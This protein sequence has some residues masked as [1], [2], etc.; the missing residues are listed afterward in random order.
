M[1]IRKTLFE[2]SLLLFVFN[3]LISQSIEIELYGNE[4]LPAREIKRKVQ[5]II[6]GGEISYEKIETLK[7]EILNLY[8]ENGFYF[9]R[10]DSIKIDGVLKIYL[11]EGEQ[12][13]VGE[14]EISGNKLFSSEDIFR[15]S[16]FKRGEIFLPRILKNRIGK[17][18]DA[19]ANVGYPLAEIEI[20]DLDF[21]DDGFVNFK[22]K[23]TE[24]KLIRIDQ[25][26]IEGN[27]LTKEDLILREMRIKKGEIYREGKLNQVKKRLTKIGLFESVEEPIIFLSDTVAG[28]LIR[29]KEAKTNFFDGV[30][31]YVPKTETTRGYFTGYINI[32]LKNL[33]G[34]GRRFGVKWN[35]ET[36]ETQEFELNY[37][38]PYVLNFPLSAEVYF[39][40]RKQDSSYVVR[41]PKLNFSAELTSSEKLSEILKTSFYISRKVVIPTATEFIGYQI[42]ESV[43]LNV[44]FGILYDSRDNVDFPSS[45]VYFSSFYELGS[46]RIIGPEKLLTPETRRKVNTNKFNF[47][48]DFYLNFEKILKSVLVPR[49]NAVIIYGD[50]L[51]ESDVFRFGGMK[52]LRGYREKEFLATRAIWLN[53]ENRFRLG[54]D[55]NIFLFSDAG[56]IYRPVILP[57]VTSSF[58]AIRYGYGVGIRLKT[59]IGKL[60]LIY[61]LGK[62]DSF[63]TGKI[64]VGVESEF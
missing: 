21:D 63:R 29:V 6:G 26:R 35:S 62:G 31:G 50:G 59:E 46:K 39:Y 16:G 3:S 1:L 51:D 8:I 11:T 10:V 53:L 12:A 36:S 57:R 34:T 28:I 38:E 17:I 25:I 45:G 30:V 4:S 49:F 23:I 19:Y 40:Q 43:S 52:T 44:G 2:V 33:F 5:E 18:L 24:G 13:K 9:A 41:E 32:T 47:S 64:H 58:E 14:V 55:F 42:F 48:L 20:S 27:K 22:L 15:I 56:Y 60:S 7:N 37:L 54:D 61:A